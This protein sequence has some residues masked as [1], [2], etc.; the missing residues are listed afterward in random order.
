MKIESDYLFVRK[1]LYFSMVLLFSIERSF[2]CAPHTPQD[3]FIARFQSATEKQLN[4]PNTVVDLSAEKFI[5]RSGLD[6]FRYSKPKQWHSSF[7]IQHIPK[8]QIIIGLAYAP[9]GNNADEYQIVSFAKLNC[10]NDRV[11]I[12]KPIAPF[13]AWNKETSNC[14]HR[15]NE[16]V[17]IL[18]GFIEH[19]QKY[20]LAKIQKQYPTCKKLREAFPA[21][22]V[23]NNDHVRPVFK[24]MWER[25]IKWIKFWL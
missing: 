4:T 7:A 13:L 22:S 21:S 1:F 15:N 17:G 25:L 3:V 19:D 2:A 16:T 6:A 20:Y 11:S 5:F 24:S 9:D 18:D 14:M 12:S 23:E 10:E 8:E